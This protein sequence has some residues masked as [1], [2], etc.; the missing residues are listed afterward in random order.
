MIDRHNTAASQTILLHETCSCPR[1][2]TCAQEA[3]QDA[4]ALIQSDLIFMFCP[5]RMGGGPLDALAFRVPDS[6]LRRLWSHCEGVLERQIP[7]GN[8]AEP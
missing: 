1:V 2:S 6:T 7:V 8:A 4:A 3:V 5:A